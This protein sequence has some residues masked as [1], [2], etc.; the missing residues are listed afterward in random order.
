MLAVCTNLG[1]SFCFLFIL[2]MAFFAF[3][4]TDTNT[5]GG[6]SESV[7]H[8]IRETTAG[9]L[10][11][12]KELPKSTVV[13][14]SLSGPWSASISVHSSH[15]ETSSD[16]SGKGCYGDFVSDSRSSKYNLSWESWSEFERFLEEEQRS[17]CVDLRKVEKS[18][19]HS[20]I[21]VFL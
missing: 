14:S 1:R 3:S 12:S 18:F 4:L 16:I 17:N 15:Q 19:Y 9:G 10:N 7:V 8:S 11:S 6:S 13:H 21:R 20:E 5:S 2:V